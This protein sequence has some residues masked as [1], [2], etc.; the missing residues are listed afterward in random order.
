VARRVEQEAPKP[1]RPART[2]PERADE[3]APNQAERDALF[4]EFLRWRERQ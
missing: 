3:G 2:A 4:Q 1:H